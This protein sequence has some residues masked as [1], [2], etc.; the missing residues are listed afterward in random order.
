MKDAETVD[1]EY[2]LRCQAWVLQKFGAEA[3]FG[4]VDFE[5]DVAI[6][7][8]CSWARYT[9]SWMEG[10]ERVERETNV[11]ELD[12]GELLREILAIDLGETT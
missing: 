6:Y 3:D 1:R 8:S 10:A 9:I 12:V 4:T 7:D 11:N 5:V 2:A